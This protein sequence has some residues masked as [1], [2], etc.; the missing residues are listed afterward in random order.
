MHC[1]AMKNHTSII[2][3]LA[4]HGA[5][6]DVT[7]NYGRTPMWFAARNGNADSVWLLV[8]EGASPQHERLLLGCPFLGNNTMTPCVVLQ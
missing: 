4:S 5:T 1:A 7:D 3:L 6:V 2:S 8:T